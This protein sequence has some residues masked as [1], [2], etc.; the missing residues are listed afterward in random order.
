MKQCA[1]EMRSAQ[2]DLSKYDTDKIRNGYLRWYDRLV[3]DAWDRF[4][5]VLEIGVHHGGSHGLWRDYFPNARI[6]GIDE[7]VTRARVSDPRIELF[8]G[9]QNDEAFLR[10]VAR[11]VAPDGFDLIIDDASHVGWLTQATFRVLFPDH[12]KPGGLYVIEDWGTGYLPEWPDGRARKESSTWLRRFLRRRGI[13]RVPWE[14]HR[15]GLVG[16]VKILIDE[17]GAGAFEETLVTG[18]LVAIRK[19]A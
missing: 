7:D 19:L 14:S 8:Q 16:F 3:G 15:Y 2:L 9:Q 12:L 6:A 11:R 18:G 17:Q 10:D 13:L 4:D 5:T 1:R